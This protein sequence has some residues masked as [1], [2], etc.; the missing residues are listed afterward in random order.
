MFVGSSVIFLRNID[1][2]KNICGLC[3]S[4]IYEVVCIYYFVDYLGKYI[5]QLG[6]RSEVI[7]FIVLGSGGLECFK[8]YVF[9]LGVQEVIWELVSIGQQGLIGMF[10]VDFQFLGTF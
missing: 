8:E 3:V 10:K 5:L 4:C 2:G 7:C 6:S 9:F 1:K